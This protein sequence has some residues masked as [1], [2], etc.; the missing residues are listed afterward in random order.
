[1]KKLGPQSSESLFDL[2]KLISNSFDLDKSELAH[3]PKK[4]QGRLFWLEIAQLTI[5][6][7][8]LLP[9]IKITS[10]KENFALTLITDNGDFRARS[11][12]SRNQVK[13]K[14]LLWEF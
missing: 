2:L 3:Q 9:G 10:L 14:I 7:Q 1:M 4:E 13:I 11:L 8:V 5:V 12:L 6:P